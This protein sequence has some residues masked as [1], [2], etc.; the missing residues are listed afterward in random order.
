MSEP[1]GEPRRR[2]GVFL[3]LSLALALS[4]AWAIWDEVVTRRPWKAHQERFAE[5]TDQAAELR[6]RQ[7]VIP[8]LDVVDRCGSCHLGTNRAGLEDAEEPLRTHPRREALLG[9]VHPPERFGCTPCH[10]GQGLALTAG[11]AHGDTDPYWLEP[12]LE[13]PM[14]E[15]GCGACHPGMDPVPEAPHLSRGRALYQQRNCGGC[16]ALTGY[17]PPRAGPSLERAFL[18]LKPDWVRRWLRDPNAIRPGTAMLSFWPEHDP[19]TIRHGETEIAHLV[20]WMSAQGEDDPAAEAEQAGDAERGRELFDGLG[21]RGCHRLDLEGQDEVL[22]IGPEDPEKKPVAAPNSDFGPAL[23]RIRHRTTRTWIAR[24]L[25]GPSKWW[26]EAKM[27]DFRLTDS[28][29]WDLATFLTSLDAPA[30]EAEPA[31]PE[32]DPEIGK[33]LAQR[34]GCA[35]CHRVPDDVGRVR[36]G[37]ELDGYAVKDVSLFDFGLDPPALDERTWLRF[38]ETKLT[39]PRATERPEVPLV[40]PDCRLEPEDVID[41]AVFLGSLDQR[42]IPDE[43]RP[44]PTAADARKAEGDRIIERLNCRGCHVIDGEGGDILPIFAEPS[45]APPTLDDLHEKVQPAWLFRFLRH[46][47]SLRPWLTARMPG[48]A[49]SVGDAEALVDRLLRRYAPETP[50]FADYTPIEMGPERLA[51]AKDFMHKLRCRKCHGRNAQKGLTMGDYA[52][53]MALVRGRLLYGWVEKFTLDPQGT[54]PNT[55]MPTFFPDGQ[56][57]LPDLLDGDVGAQ[58]RLLTDY[59]FSTSFTPEEATQ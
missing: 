7:V 1:S 33:E 16:H 6:I 17:D 57:P 52:P 8:A 20:A 51:M 43:F 18:K 44:E 54:I 23:G 40:M 19:E 46:P 13:G 37:P 55:R 14:I 4:G 27:P 22:P 42:R 12:I 9:S 5:L 58:V 10:R 47:R 38:T 53:D 35:G 50:T 15:A 59:L 25:A 28:E 24:W 39:A 48:F 41:L 56:T 2:P 49:L 30:P 21:C 29:R 3:F 32:G 34:Y 36:V 31:G 45:T 26:A 11:D